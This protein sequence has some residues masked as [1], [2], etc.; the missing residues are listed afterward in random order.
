MEQR[1][2]IPGSEARHESGGSWLPAG[3]DQQISPTII[4]RRPQ[5]A[6]DMSEQLL[7]G[8]LRQM[9]RQ[10]AENLLRVD[11]ADL[12]AVLT[13]VQNYGLS[14]VTENA[15]ARTVQVE[16]SAIQV[17]Q[18]FGVEIEWRIDPEGQRYLSYQ[19][20]LSVPANLAGIVEAVLG[21]DQRPAARRGVG[22]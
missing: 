12:A 15:E 14:V 6:K 21:L 3:A 8:S 22:R 13:F 2:A 18:A 7:S 1:S 5:R 4:I 20:P 10:E 11:P 9:S 16:G 17:G 19:G